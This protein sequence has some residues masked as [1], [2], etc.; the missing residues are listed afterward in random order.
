MTGAITLNCSLKS[1]LF[2][3]LGDKAIIHLCT[4]RAGNI[5]AH[6]KSHLAPAAV[7]AVISVRQRRTIRVWGSVSP[8]VAFFSLAKRETDRSPD[9]LITHALQQQEVK[10]RDKEKGGSWSVGKRR[11]GKSYWTRSQR[12]STGTG[13]TLVQVLTRVNG[14]W[15]DH[16]IEF[17]TQTL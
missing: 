6:V 7:R 16:V 9:G 12:G 11:G 13:Q 5:V 4:S 15:C 10:G 14:N 1:T 3:L 8:T 2:A 17:C